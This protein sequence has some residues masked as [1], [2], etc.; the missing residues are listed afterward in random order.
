[1][2]DEQQQ[3]IARLEQEIARLQQA[4]AHNND[5]IVG[6]ERAFLDT[7][8]ELANVDD[9]FALR[10]LGKLHN[11]VRDFRTDEYNAL[12]EK[13]EYGDPDTALTRPATLLSRWILW[14]DLSLLIPPDKRR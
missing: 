12:R 2:S 3:R 9:R 7:V 6:L 8:Y 5:L 14:S 13:R 1:M 10:L 4:V 11:L